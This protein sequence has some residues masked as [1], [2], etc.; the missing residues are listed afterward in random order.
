MKHRQTRVSLFAQLAVLSGLLVGLAPAVRAD[1]KHPPV[2]CSNLVLNG[3][4]GF[5]RT[6]VD[7]DGPTVSIGIIVY[8]GHGNGTVNQSISFAGVFEFDLAGGFTYQI[9]DDCTG[10]AFNGDGEE[11]T[12]LVVFDDGKGV[13]LMGE[14]DG[15]AVIGVGSRIHAGKH[16]N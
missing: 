15:S 6:G 4:Y 11:T 13:Y 2:A 12:R 9:D 3:S 7:T 5:Y 1:D 14:Q 16:D 10:K 8:D